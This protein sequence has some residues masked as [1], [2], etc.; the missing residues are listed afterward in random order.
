MSVAMPPVTDDLA[1]VY[2]AFLRR[3]PP[4]TETVNGILWRF[5]DTS[6]G[7]DI[8]LLLPGALGRGETAFQYIMALAGRFRVLSLDYPTE[9][10]RMGDLCDGIVALLDMLGVYSVHLVGGSFGGLIAQEFASRY[11]TRVRRLVL[12]DA[13]PPMRTHLPYLYTARAALRFLP[14]AT[15]R[16]VIRNGIRDYLAEMPD[17]ERVFWTRHFLEALTTLSRAD[18]ATRADLWAE[19]DRRVPSTDNRSG[20]LLVTA[21]GD[22]MIT[23]AVQRALLRRYPRAETYTIHG[24]GHAASLTRADEYIAVI[25]AFLEADL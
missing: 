13:P 14:E 7:E 22:R 3:Y 20:V 15:V 18:F 2:E 24:G 25:R 23:P 17:A 6:A 9:L 12:T 10:R 1:V 11:P 21:A 16:G 8:A 4:R 19:F 5:V